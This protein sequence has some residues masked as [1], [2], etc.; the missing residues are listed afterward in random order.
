MFSEWV[1]QQ[2]LWYKTT[3]TSCELESCCGHCWM[4]LILGQSLSVLPKPTAI[5]SR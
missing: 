4:S 1:T 3:L 5:L 2:G